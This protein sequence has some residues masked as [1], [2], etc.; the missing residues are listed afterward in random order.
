MIKNGFSLFEALLSVMILGSI[1]TGVILN[2]VENRNK[3]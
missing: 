1:S 3:D 2:Q